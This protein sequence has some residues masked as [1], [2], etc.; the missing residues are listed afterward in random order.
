MSIT[1]CHFYLTF[2]QGT[3]AFYLISYWIITHLCRPA[4]GQ[5]IV[6]V[7]NLLFMPTSVAYL[8][9]FELFQVGPSPL[10][11]YLLSKAMQTGLEKIYAAR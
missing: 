1:F 3:T 9:E 5:P 7:G 4:I 10:T 2:C 8:N 11:F 6:Y